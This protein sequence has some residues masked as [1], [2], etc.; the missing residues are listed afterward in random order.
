MKV[1]IQALAELPGKNQSIGVGI[2]VPAG[3]ELLSVELMLPASPVLGGPAAYVVSVT[4]PVPRTSIG[5]S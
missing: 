5:S 4:R 2:N 3:E 1:Y